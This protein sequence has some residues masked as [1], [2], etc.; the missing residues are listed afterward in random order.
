MAMAHE[1]ADQNSMIS[2][3]LTKSL[4]W[5]GEGTPEDQHLLDS[6]AS[7]FFS[8]LFFLVALV[9]LMDFGITLSLSILMDFLRS[10]RCWK[11]FGLY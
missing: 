8:F 10:A 3:A 11:L 5:R 1:I 4:I 9:N 6:K 2:M 7:E